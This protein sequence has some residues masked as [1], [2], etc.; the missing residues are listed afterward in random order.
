MDEKE[1]NRVKEW[2]MKGSI[3]QRNKLAKKGK[4]EDRGEARWKLPLKGKETSPTGQRCVRA[5]LS[6]Y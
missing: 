6:V 5:V 4:K 1:E 2:R 3:K